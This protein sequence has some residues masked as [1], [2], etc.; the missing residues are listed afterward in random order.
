MPYRVGVKPQK[1]AS[2]IGMVAG[3]LFVLLGVT[4]IVPIFGAFG[5][6]WTAVAAAITV[7]Y[8]YNLFSSRGT[9]AYE[10]NV[11]SQDNMEDLDAG[12]RRLAKLIEDGLLT[13]QE[14]EQKRA[15]VPRGQ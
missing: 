2:A 6:V 10:V 1:A 14:Y 5:M 13:D 9:S 4:M 12:L 3:G 11:E 15:E 7:F 8:A